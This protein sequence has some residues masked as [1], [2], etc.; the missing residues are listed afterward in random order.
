[1]RTASVLLVLLLGLSAFSVIFLA[2]PR[3]ENQVKTTTFATTSTFTATTTISLTTTIVI[4]ETRQGW[5]PS[6]AL[7]EAVGKRYPNQESFETYHIRLPNNPG[8][9]YY[10][11]AVFWKYN[12]NHTHIIYFHLPENKQMAILP[13][14]TIQIRFVSARYLP[15]IPAPWP[16]IAEVVETVFTGDGFVSSRAWVL[17]RQIPGYPSSP[18]VERSG[19][20]AWVVSYRPLDSEPAGESLVARYYFLVIRVIS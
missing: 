1:M 7:V 16:P 11:F 19:P 10:S 5:D 9:Y 8:T 6:S 20:Q 17:N 3:G 4:T 13:D 2:T 14:S 15:N 12:Q 18:Q